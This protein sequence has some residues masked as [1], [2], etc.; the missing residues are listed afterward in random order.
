M[1]EINNVEEQ[2]AIYGA[3]I[4]GAGVSSTHVTISN[5]GGI[6]YVS[7]GATDKILE[8][9]WAWDGNEDSSGI[10]FLS[11]QGANGANDRV[12]VDDAYINWGGTSAGA[13]KEPDDY[14]AIGLAG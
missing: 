5:G 8:G 9:T 10:N 6:A 11:G 14:G 13:A 3:I 7:I 1:V 4:N 12:V 2:N